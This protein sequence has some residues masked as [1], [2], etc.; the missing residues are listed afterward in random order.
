M[1]YHYYDPNHCLLAVILCL[2]FQQVVETNAQLQNTIQSLKN[3]RRDNILEI[4]QLKNQI[5]MLGGEG[6]Q[7]CILGSLY[8][9]FSVPY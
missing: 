6:A 1:P 8:P 3:E 7:V 2:L 5:V 9:L 4:Q